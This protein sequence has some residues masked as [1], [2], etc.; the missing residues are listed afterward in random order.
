MAVLFK[1]TGYCCKKTLEMS[2]YGGFAVALEGLL[3][4]I[5]PYMPSFNAEKMRNIPNIRC[6][7]NTC[8]LLI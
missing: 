3:L 6:K 4:H 7:N 8:V 2:G 5:V 1:S